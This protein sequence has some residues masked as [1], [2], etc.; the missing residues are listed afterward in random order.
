MTRSSPQYR[1]GFALVSIVSLPY[2]PRRRRQP[3]VSVS[4]ESRPLSGA[5]TMKLFIAGT[6]LAAAT[7]AAPAI[8][9]EA[10]LP[11]KAPPT[12]AVAS[13]NGLY[14]WMD[15]SYQSVPLPTFNLGVQ[16]DTA[17]G[18]SGGPFESYSPRANGY[19]VAGAVGYFLPYGTL[20]SAFGTNV[21][22][23]LGGSYVDATASQSGTGP[24]NGTPGLLWQLLNGQMF[25][26]TNCVGRICS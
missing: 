15:G 8:A 17:A 19:G 26:D 7:L 14:L 5:M 11:I 22:V 16:R 3:M 1:S 10:D 23:E 20:P 9:A 6:A 12:A 24:D 21:R 2:E 13:S 4:V 25:V 18:F